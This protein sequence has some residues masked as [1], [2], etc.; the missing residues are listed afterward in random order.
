GKEEDVRLGANKFLERQPI[1]TAAQTQDDRKAYT[2]TVAMPFYDP[3]ELTSWCST[4]GFEGI[5]W[6]F[7]G[8]IFVLVYYSSGI[9]GEHINL[10]V[11]FGLFLARKL[12][13]TTVVFYMVM[14]TWEPYAVLLRLKGFMGNTFDLYGGEVNFVSPSYTTG[15]ELGFKIMGTFI[16]VYTVLSA[17]DGK[18]NARDSHVPILAPLSI[19]FTVLLVHL[20]T[21]P[22][23][24]TGINPVRSLVTTLLYNMEYAW[25]DQW[26][27]WAD[28][29]IGA[30]LATLYHMLVIRPIPFK[31][32]VKIMI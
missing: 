6:A 28:P 29:F 9:L 23:I 11:T 24:A 26:I 8:T 10:A 32:T 18:R 22:I 31:S 13:M 5:T 30:A 2:K 4:V 15:D 16:L 3:H 21:I 7:G 25:K 27:F 14:H 12:T 19:R 17:T 1:E 20:A